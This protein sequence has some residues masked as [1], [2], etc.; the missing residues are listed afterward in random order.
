MKKSHYKNKYERTAEYVY[1]VPFEGST[2]AGK[3]LRKLKN[4]T[5]PYTGIKMISGSVLK[6]FEKK[7]NECIN[8]FDIVRLLS[9]YSGNLQKTEKSVFAIFKDFVALNPKDNIQN[10]LQMLYNS[11]LTKLKLEEFLVLDDVDML[12]RGLSPA[13]ALKVRAKTTR[14]REIIIANNQ[15]DTFK[16]RIFVDSLD[17][18][19]PKENEKDILEN[20]KDRALF[21]P[22]SGSSRNAF[23]VKYA[24]RSQAEAARRIFIASTATIEHV[25]P[26]SEGGSNHIGNFMLV[27]ANGNRYRENL[28]LV[29]YINRHPMVP[30]YVQMYMN[31]IIDAI[32]NG[33]LKGNEDYPYLIK[34]KLID[35]SMG[36]L[37]PSLSAY[38]YTE[39]EAVQAAQEYA[40]SKHM[41]KKDLK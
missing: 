16:R 29:K 32:H 21:L 34:Q 25:T 13:T 4:I 30:A 28:P 35:E 18:I 22:T 36:R 7:L 33:E 8:A 2:S 38:K 19:K 17:E 31:D 37:T 39:K 41:K 26:A 11:C 20:I 1:G 12:T 6:S 3:P 10:C 24:T 27:S 9:D 23:V 5:C 40:A 15:A 14:C